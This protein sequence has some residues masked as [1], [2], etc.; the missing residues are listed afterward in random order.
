MLVTL[1]GHLKADELSR[2]FIYYCQLMP[3]MYALSLTV[4]PVCLLHSFTCV[5]LEG[6]LH[7]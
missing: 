4:F 2:Q 7:V 1:F 3:A 5:L 6:K